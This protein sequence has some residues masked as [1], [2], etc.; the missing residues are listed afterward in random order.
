MGRG[1]FFHF[2]SLL[3]TASCRPHPAVEL[4]TFKVT[5]CNM[6]MEYA[7]ANCRL[8]CIVLTWADNS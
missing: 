5:K 3:T 1:R 4:M 2:R 8:L 6:R 7:H